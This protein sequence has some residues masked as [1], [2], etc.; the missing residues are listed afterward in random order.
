MLEICKN[1]PGQGDFITALKEILGLCLKVPLSLQ[2][3]SEN[4]ASTTIL[5]PVIDLFSAN[6]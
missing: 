1:L 4:P 6:N 2:E 5:T 3:P